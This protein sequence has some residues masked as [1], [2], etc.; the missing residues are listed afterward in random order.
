MALSRAR[1]SARKLRSGAR[2][3]QSRLGLRMGRG[4]FRKARRKGRVGAKWSTV[5][6]YRRLANNPK[7]GHTYWGKK[8]T[9]GMVG[10]ARVMAAHTRM[11]A[12]SSKGAR[13][14]RTYGE[15]SK[16]HGSRVGRW[17]KILANN[18]AQFPMP[19]ASALNPGRG[20]RNPGG[21]DS[22]VIEAM[23][24]KRSLDSEADVM[25]AIDEGMCSPSVA[26]K[27]RAWL[28]GSSTTRSGAPKRRK[29][30][31]SKRRGRNSRKSTRRSSRKSRKSRGS[32]TT[33]GSRKSH[34]R[35]G[36]ARAKGRRGGNSKRTLNRA[37]YHARGGR[38]ARNCGR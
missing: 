1:R 16:M 5:K 19:F 36:R 28:K 32:R 3:K 2:R 23:G 7:K 22:M 10:D 30:R 35:A 18:P 20:R 33:R 27:G 31:S 9:R 6:K 8:I 34:R 4:G 11:M 29:G 15:I 21:A 24:M 37:L 26:A 17:S 38:Y 25:M 12:R 13:I 14:R